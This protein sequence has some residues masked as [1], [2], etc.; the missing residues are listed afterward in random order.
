MLGEAWLSDRPGGVASLV[1]RAARE[2]AGLVVVV[3]GDGTVH[4]A[5]N[6]LLQSDADTVP[7]LAVLPQGTG[8]DL[9]RGLGIP[10]GLDEALAVITD[11]RTRTVDVG[12]ARYTAAD[13]STRES[14]FASMAGTGM[15]GAVA[16]RLNV[17]TKALGGRVSSLIATLAVFRRWKNVEMSIE[18]DG[19]SRRALIE[20]VLVGNTEFH[21]GGMRLCPGATPD[22]GLLDALIIGD[23]SKK[24]LALT[25]PKLYRGTHL[26]HPMAELRRARTISI[27]AATPLPVELD[28]EQPGT[29]PVRFDVEPGALRVRVPPTIDR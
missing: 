13:G 7:E 22:D 25:L 18:I 27:D 28:G 8:D 20:D 12:R 6:G 3:G 5:V 19:E 21:N 15:S 24:D 17:T 16:R 11:G 10:G 1:A 26:P 2:G 14:F 4:E 23:I 9:A 29:T